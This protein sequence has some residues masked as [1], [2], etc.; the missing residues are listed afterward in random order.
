MERFQNVVRFALQGHTHNEDFQVNLSLTHPDRAVSVNSV[1]GSVTPYTEKN[2][3]FMV[4][5]FDA[6]TMLPV[7]MKTY[8]FNLEEANASPDQKPNWALLHDWINTYEMDDFSPKS[9]LKLS[10]R[11]KTNQNL[12]NTYT[13]N[14]VRQYGPEPT[15]ADGVHLFCNT[16]CSEAYQYQECVAAHGTSMEYEVE[17]INQ[18]TEP[19]VNFHG[20]SGSSIG[21]WLIGNWVDIQD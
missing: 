16:S 8:S 15:S 12:A 17:G 13:W 5:D 19:G 6:E 10:E 21:D 20:L 4:I 2:P 11:F 7:N 9:F 14:R 18:A 3:S 1:G